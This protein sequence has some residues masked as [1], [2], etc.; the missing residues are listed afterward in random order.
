M[1]D[2]ANEPEPP[3]H[4]FLDADEVTP[5]TSALRLLIADE[6]HE[7]QIRGLAR[8]VIANLDAAPDERGKLT[9]TLNPGQMKITHTALKLLL[10]DLQR[11]QASEREILRRIIDKLPDEHTMR[12]I[13]LP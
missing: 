3:Y 2:T 4:L 5:A 11:G 9:V 10:G 6:A 7:P 12:A 13:R 1:T 8:E